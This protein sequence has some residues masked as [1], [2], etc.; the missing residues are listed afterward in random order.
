MVIKELRINGR[1]A[2]LRKSRKAHKCAECGLLIEPG[3]YYYSVVIG[4]GGLGSL[5]FPDRYHVECLK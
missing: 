3:E 5:K 2:D 1:I 4:G